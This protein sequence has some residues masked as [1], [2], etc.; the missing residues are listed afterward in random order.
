MP[1]VNIKKQYLAFGMLVFVVLFLFNS[2][3]A[4]QCQFTPEVSTYVPT[5]Y[6]ITPTY[7]RLAQKADLTRLSQ[8]LM[9]VKN[10]HWIVIEDS[11]TK[12]SLVENLLKESTLKYT[13]L[14]VKTHKSKH[15]TVM[16]VNICVFKTETITTSWYCA[17]GVEQR[18]VALNWLRGH[19]KDSDDKRGAVYF[20]DD[21]NTYS[22][23]VFDEMRKIKK[24]GVWPV[25]IVGGMRV[26]MP[27]V[28]DGKVSGFNAVWKPFRPFPI[29]M[30]GFAINATL[31]LLH[32]EAKFSRKVQSGFQESEILKYV[33]T[34]DDLEPL[35]ENCTKV[36]VWHTRT[37]KPS[38]LNPKKLKHP[39]LPDDHIEV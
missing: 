22:L 38:I 3:P 25:G 2:R 7:A 30:A 13:H 34:K 29:D 10:F 24:V 23:K 32:P 12:T 39:P 19:L 37:Q 8:T 20:M 26:E 21:D 14:N 18:N 4:I 33:A 27:L 36:Y 31:F 1:F 16:D 5:I 28:T 17:S 6:G 35:A 9:L 15:S 11:E